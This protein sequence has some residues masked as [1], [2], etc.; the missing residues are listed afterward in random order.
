MKMDEK[1]DFVFVA[2]DDA[3]LLFLPDSQWQINSIKFHFEHE[4]AVREN[5]GQ[6][7]KVPCRNR[8]GWNP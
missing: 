2:W 1:A 6:L 5:S 4:N 8:S 3:A 7:D